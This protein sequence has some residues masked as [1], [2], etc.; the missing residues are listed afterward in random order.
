LCEEPTVVITVLD[1]EQA[2]TDLVA[3]VLTCP[4]SWS[5]LRPSKPMSVALAMASFHRAL[6]SSTT[7]AVAE[8]RFCGSASLL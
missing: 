1:T 7:D 6:P 2:D 5:V 3:G 8:T 4:Q